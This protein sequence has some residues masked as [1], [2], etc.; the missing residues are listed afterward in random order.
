MYRMI[1][2]V[3]KTI[4]DEIEALTLALK[5]EYNP[6]VD[7]VFEL[8]DVYTEQHTYSTWNGEKITL[9]D[10]NCYGIERKFKVIHVSKE[11]IPFLRELSRKGNP[12]GSVRTI[13]RL[14][15]IAKG[16]LCYS[17]PDSKWIL[18]ENLVNA[19]MLDQEYD[20]MIEARERSNLFRDIA[21]HN[22]EKRIDVSTRKITADFMNN[23][24][25]GDKIWKKTNEFFVVQSPAYPDTENPGNILIQVIDHNNKKKQ[26]S[27]NDLCRSRIYSDQPRSYKKEITEHT[28]S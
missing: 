15:V 26:I 13:H 16:P 5:D 14:E 1:K 3:P 18:D 11:G 22:K 21:R 7:G 24:K 10:T 27:L 23:L 25:A 19:I 28:L 9:K 12:I 2:I 4:E 6:E 20:P 17:N 8:G